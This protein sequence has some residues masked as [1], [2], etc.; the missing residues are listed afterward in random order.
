M[1]EYP[2][3]SLN[4][5]DKYVPEME[6]LGVSKVARSR[7]GFLPAYRRANGNPSNL[8]EYWR[9]KRHGFIARHL[10]QY[11]KGQARRRLALIAWAYDPE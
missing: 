8:S 4:I 11:R 7:R 5:I 1:S 2:Y 6:A 9:R 3:L 10:A